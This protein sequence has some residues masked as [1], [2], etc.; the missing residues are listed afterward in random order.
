[1]SNLSSFSIMQITLAV[2]A[3]IAIFALIVHRTAPRQAAAKRPVSRPVMI[4]D[5]WGPVPYEPEAF[6]RPLAAEQIKPPARPVWRGHSEVLPSE[7][8]AI[9]ARVE[10][11]LKNLQRRRP[12][13][14]VK[15]ERVSQ[16]EFAKLFP[17]AAF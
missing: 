11:T 6:N 3:L 2:V 9:A 14:V 1:M 12:A 13:V 15:E 7:E 4:A 17:Q 5:P 16:S 10:D 8:A